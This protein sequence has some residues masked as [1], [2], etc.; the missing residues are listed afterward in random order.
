MNRMQDISSQKPAIL[1]IIRAT[2]V[3]VA[4]AAGV[5]LFLWLWLGSE[6]AMELAERVPGT[7]NVVG[8]EPSTQIEG[9]VFSGK[10]HSLGN[11]N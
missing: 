9:D 3:V 2:P 5:I 11:V 7:D 4:V 6:P 1:S 8:E 10:L